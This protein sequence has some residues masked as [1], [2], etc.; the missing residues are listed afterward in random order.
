MALIQN[1]CINFVTVTKNSYMKFRLFSILAAL[2]L[3]FGMGVQAQNA[4]GLPA[5]I[6]QGNILHC[7][8]WRLS[9]IKAE[10]PKIAE[11]GFVAIQTSPLQR[12]VQSGWNWSDVYRPYDFAFSNSGLGTANDL[13]SL[14]EE[15]DKYGIQII[16][17]VVFN[18]VD[19]GS[20]HHSWWNSNGRLRSG[21]SYI[22]YGNRNS[23]TH[24]LMGDFPDVNTEQPEVIARAKAYIEELKGYGV[25]GVRFD[26]AKH[27]GLPSEG[28]DFWAEVTSVPGIFYYG[29]ILDGPGGS[30]STQ[31]LKEYSTF[32]SITDSSYSDGARRTDGVPTNKAGW[33]LSTIDESLCVY[34]GESHDT[35]ANEGGASKN[36]S[37][38]QVDRAYAI[39]SS[40]NK[41]VGL[42]F[43]RPSQKNFGDIRVGQKGST[44]FTESPVAEVN[45][46]KNEMVGKAD[47]YTRGD[48]GASVT[49]QGG[50][51]VI[52]RKGGSGAITVANGNGYCPAGTYYDRVSGGKFTVT[53]SSITG[54]VGASG[55]AVIYGDYVPEDG[56][57]DD[58]VVE[59]YYI[60]CTNPLNWDQVYVYMYSAGGATYTNGSWPGQP[61]TLNEGTWEYLVPNELIYS[62]KVIFNDGKN[63]GQ[64]PADVPGI[65]SGF[66]FNAKN[67]ISDGENSWKEYVEAG[68][69]EI[70]ADEFDM[71]GARWFTLQGVSV[72]NP[73]QPGIYIVCSPQGKTK[74]VLVK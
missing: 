49:R 29:E 33:G 25:K 30:Q 66:D 48:N 2:S 34:W 22:N 4:Y 10:L 52:V 13:K 46:F 57:K 20:Y 45:K 63:G 61:M 71:E 6:K 70:V 18:H 64:Y 38:A 23:I 35:Y 59:E 32:M 36:V 43:S 39:L 56:P 44:H 19:K 7:F 1:I 58:P 41:G 9:D 47:C 53:E 17:D 14:C 5:E 51:A 68:V 55:I 50:G 40:R 27:I 28:S 72:K 67:M 15:A 3:M 54:T 74:K 37:Q 65:E 42:Y 16:V 24:D 8:D 69:D 62:S 26:A 21:T 11:A 73:S 60:Y 12:N 31:L